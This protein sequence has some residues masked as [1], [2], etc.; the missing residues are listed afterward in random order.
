MKNSFYVL[1]LIQSSHPP[2]QNGPGQTL[3]LD[4]QTLAQ[5]I[6]EVFILLWLQIGVGGG[7]FQA[8]TLLQRMCNLGSHLSWISQSPCASR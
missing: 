3:E 7:K 8:L 1:T 4:I 2:V 5:Q 6:I